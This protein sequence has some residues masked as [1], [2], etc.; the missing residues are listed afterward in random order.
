MAH[1]DEITNDTIEVYDES[2]MTRR[3]VHMQPL[4][5]VDGTDQIVVGGALGNWS[6]LELGE[7]DTR[8]VYRRLGEVIK[9]WDEQDMEGM[10]TQAAPLVAEMALAP[11]QI[12]TDEDLP[13]LV[14][15]A[16]QYGILD[17]T[18]ELHPIGNRTGDFLL[19]GRVDG[20]R[21]VSEPLGSRYLIDNRR[22]G[23]EGVWHTLQTIR[24]ELK[25]LEEN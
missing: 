18:V 15:Y 20:A 14:G 4:V 22:G 6:F 8:E 11:S 3:L 1:R 10:A 17:K 5:D 9:A 21:R 23:L 25:A 16:R 7:S 13:L 12:L 24:H 19:V 2:T